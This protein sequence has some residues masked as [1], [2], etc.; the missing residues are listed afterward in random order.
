MATKTFEE[1][2][3][4]AIQI[5]DEKT[6]KQNTAT[7]VGTAMLE[8]IN[9]L[10][11]D[12]Y[13]K[14]TIN[15]RTSEYNV[16][17]NHPTSGISSSNKYDLSSAIAQ[18]P[19]ELRTAGLKV[20][21][22]NSV[23][24]PESWKYQGGSWAVA[25]FIQESSGGNKILTW[26]TNA[27]TTRKQ[28]SVNE[29]KA[30]MQISYKPTDSDWVNE[31]Y[32][33]TAFDDTNWA[34]D[35]NWE[36]IPNQEQIAELYFSNNISDSALLNSLFNY[37]RITGNILISDVFEI[38]VGKRSDESYYFFIYK[39]NASKIIEFP[40]TSWNI[41]KETELYLSGFNIKIYFNPKSNHSDVPRCKLNM[42]I[43][44]YN[45][46]YD[47]QLNKYLANI[48]IPIYKE[49]VYLTIQGNEGTHPDPCGVTD[50]FP[51]DSSLK[52][53]YKGY[54]A[55]GVPGV[56]FLDKDG[57]A[58]SYTDSGYN[59]TIYIEKIFD[60]PDGAVMARAGYFGKGASK[61]SF[62]C[63]LLSSALAESYNRLEEAEYSIK[64]LSGEPLDLGVLLQDKYLTTDGGQTGSWN[65]GVTTRDF[66]KVK[67]NKKYLYTGR[68]GLAACPVLY[69]ASDQETILGYIPLSSPQIDVVKLEFT[70]PEDC[71]YIKSCSLN[72]TLE[73]IPVGDV[74]KES[75]DLLQK[76]I[77][78][79]N[80]LNPLYRK[81]FFALGDSITIGSGASDSNG[82]P[83]NPSKKV[84]G[85]LIA[86]R[87]EM[88]FHNFGVGGTLVEKQDPKGRTIAYYNNATL[89]SYEE[90][91]N[92]TS[93]GDN[94][95]TFTTP[96]NCNELWVSVKTKGYDNS[97]SL[98]ISEGS[99]ISDNL[100][101][102]SQNV[103]GKY[104]RYDGKEKE[105][106]DAI[107]AKIPVKP[108]TT[109]TIVYNN[110]V[111]LGANTSSF[112]E[113]FEKDILPILT[114]YD[115]LYFL[116]KG[117]TNDRGRLN[118]GD[119]NSFCPY[120]YYGALNIIIK[121]ILKTNPMTHLGLM[122]TLNI[123]DNSTNDVARMRQAVKDLGE[124]YSV[125]V[126]DLY[127][128]SSLPNPSTLDGE[129]SLWNDG[130]I[131]PNDNGYLRLSWVVEH[132][133]RGL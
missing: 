1:L 58:I 97:S 7:R 67:P 132:F 57:T 5:R 52:I 28:V 13:D 126:L 19:A 44:N 62:S 94:T 91:K 131:H 34:K 80:A 40:S 99:A 83:T 45:T 18:V 95:Y 77:N 64:E 110:A 75:I 66:V 11:Q 56:V 68:Y 128:C 31:Q 133:M 41:G 70:T 116:I 43:V 47:L 27:A 93:I 17:I 49:D 114:D 106:S 119:I 32:V 130:G 118:L 72:S 81:T 122:T 61:D 92:L 53:Y 3:Q 36:K 71:Y 59:G 102:Q 37:L 73:I 48:N 55:K 86:E 129:H 90:T 125:P 16:S 63:V 14:T 12:Y 22:L 51:V 84:W 33:G 8:H 26:V 104:V 96:E 10:E 82:S 29:R 15:N 112:V 85:Y 65:G 101:I 20:S 2:K 111:I 42:D 113:R 103:T 38:S 25:N 105:E 88:D 121:N 107:L 9:K 108:N 89:L 74:S 123:T 60:V 117:G 127:S 54:C 78:G 109:Y 50:K 35:D 30:G 23:G 39:N 124:K 79:I 87:N 4:L 98:V 69:Y 120:E 100:Y 115:E 76:Q 21:F 6:N 24:K 46:I